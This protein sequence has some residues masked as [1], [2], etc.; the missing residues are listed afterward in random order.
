MQEAELL[1]R[2]YDFDDVFNKELKT[3]KN[4]AIFLREKTGL[5]RLCV[6]P[7]EYA[8]SAD[9][10]GCHAAS[11]PHTATPKI[12]TGAGDHFNAGYFTGLLIGLEQKLALQLGVL[13]SGYYVR[14][15]MSHSLNTILEFAQLCSEGKAEE[16]C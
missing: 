16:I 5:D 15:A 9:K 13:N 4:L 12:S 3:V 10:T 11:A 6:H 8:V 1:S 7:K 2:M 14:T